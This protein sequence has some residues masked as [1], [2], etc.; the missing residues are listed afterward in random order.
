MVWA[1][2]E[3]YSNWRWI[4]SEKL[5]N[6]HLPSYNHLFY[7]IWEVQFFLVP[8][9]SC[10]KFVTFIRYRTEHIRYGIPLKLDLSVVLWSWSWKEPKL[11]AGDRAG[12]GILKFRLRLRVSWRSIWKSN[13]I[14]NRIKQVNELDILSLKTWKIH[15]LIWKLC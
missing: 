13:F 7:L 12:A 14:L 10:W 4:Y 8:R 5:I 6:K 11:L 1:L 2:R 9:P 3:V 15:F